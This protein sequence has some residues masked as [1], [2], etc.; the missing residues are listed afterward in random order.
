ME[1]AVHI[2]PRKPSLNPVR[3][4]LPFNIHIITISQSKSYKHML[5]GKSTS[6]LFSSGSFNIS[7]EFFG[8]IISVLFV[9][10]F[11]I[12]MLL[13]L[14]VGTDS[15]G[16]H[17]LSQSFLHVLLA[18][19]AGGLL[20]DVFLHLIPHALHS[21]TPSSTRT[22]TQSKSIDPP[23]SASYKESCR[24]LPFTCNRFARSH[25]PYFGWALCSWW[26]LFVLYH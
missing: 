6:L 2:T 26:H 19:A 11:P 24:P 15:A 23:S 13:F 14:P 5:P 18:F 3:P 16:K 12:I 10:I 8:T 7:P 1:A 22:P 4:K 20:G 21:H 17:L 25:R 9:G